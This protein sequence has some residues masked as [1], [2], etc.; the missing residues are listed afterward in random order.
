MRD[1]LD[2]S[3]AHF[4]GLTNNLSAPKQVEGDEA[5]MI[6]IN[7]RLNSGIL[8][9]QQSIELDGLSASSEVTGESRWT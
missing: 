6:S 8:V 4:K 5:G 1:K 9:D 2:A 7:P 3:G